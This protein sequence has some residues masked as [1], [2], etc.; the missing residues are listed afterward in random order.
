MLKKLLF[1]SLC[2]ISFIT[3]AV[4]FAWKPVLINSINQILLSAQRGSNIQLLEVEGFSISLQEIHI[5][6]LIFSIDGRQQRIKNLQFQGDFSLG[7]VEQIQIQ[8][9]Q[10]DLPPTS[11]SDHTQQSPNESFD[12]SIQQLS[13]RIQES[14][15]PLHG[16]FHLTIDAIR[17]RQYASMPALKV[18]IAV[19][20]QQ[21]I[22]ADIHLG[23][24]ILK[25][26]IKLATQQI[27]FNSQLNTGDK[28][29][30]LWAQ[31][32]V[33]KDLPQRTHCEL[34]SDIDIQQL[35]AMLQ[36]PG[37]DTL[38]TPFKDLSQSQ[39]RWH[40]AANIHWPLDNATLKDI[41]A[42]LTL[43]AKTASDLQLTSILDKPAI[44]SMQ[45][46]TQSELQLIWQQQQLSQVGSFDIKLKIFDKQKHALAL[47]INLSESVCDLTLQCSGKIK[48]QSILSSSQL[49]QHLLTQSIFSDLTFTQLK[50]KPLLD[51][52]YDLSSQSDP[53]I[54]IKISDGPFIHIKNLAYD[55]Y[56]A[57][58]AS[59]K[60]N[61]LQINLNDKS[62]Q[63]QSKVLNI[64]LNHLHSDK[65]TAEKLIIQGRDLH[66][67]H[68]DTGLTLQS[69]I[70]IQ[71]IKP[72][73][74][75][76]SMTL[77]D[78]QLSGPI[79][80][81]KDQLNVDLTLRH[82]KQKIITVN[83]IHLQEANLGHGQWLIPP[84]QLSDDTPLHQ[85]LGL[86]SL[87]VWI[88]TGL[89]SGQGEFSWGEKTALS[90]S[91][92]FNELGG[93]FDDY[94]FSGFNGEILLQG[95][96][97]A[98]SYASFG[99][100]TM[101]EVN[102]GVPIKDLAVSIN[103]RSDDDV[104][105]IQDFS[106]KLLDGE[107]IL[108]EY[109]FDLNTD[110]HQ[111]LL[112]LENLSLAQVIN[113]VNTPGLSGTGQMNG[114]LPFAINANNFTISNGLLYSTPPGGTIHYRDTA[115]GDANL[116]MSY[117]YKALGNYHYRQM[118][119]TVDL[120]DQGKLLLGV[121]MQ[122][123][124]PDFENGRA[125]N[126]NLNMDDDIMQQMRSFNAI[127]SVTEKVEKHYQQ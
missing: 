111:G 92:R 38:F 40:L 116:A 118:I 122:G 15:E 31:H 7:K 19:K 74:A 43:T 10:L 67:Q 50:F 108:D 64:S 6:N 91:L 65:A 48:L 4:I 21:Q 80:L 14:L 24:L 88:N 29:Q 125:I 94:I 71:G 5:K 35:A 36:Q 33:C 53:A 49:K 47:Q 61:N 3:G 9:L 114:R 46:Q 17:F 97:R 8:S 101:A 1:S 78:L 124:N 18:A 28:N 25:T 51:W 72:T 112:K 121:S 115:I 68:G 62:L 13:T 44:D 85:L 42:G 34:D 99:K 90:G 56:V 32:T 102:M 66:L 110:S 109:Q 57:K 127:N 96:D 70:H 98:L 69:Q 73:L 82:G 58:T 105:R 75:D 55:N 63:L 83:G 12:L 113:V 37:I 95:D 86:N 26:Q 104:I 87:P 77:A 79:S 89:I 76:S 60:T 39:G 106:A 30:V 23:E 119:S 41:E 2:I 52:R 100:L 93:L 27:D 126:L 22:S 117:V 59:I 11:Q 107:L 84:M 20:D 16:D 123:H 45:L 103:G 81:K 54:Q 120:T